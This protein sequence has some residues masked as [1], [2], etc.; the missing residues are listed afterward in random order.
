MLF[1]IMS[2]GNTRSR[3]AARHAYQ[4]PLRTIVYM[5]RMEKTRRCGDQV[6]FVIRASSYSEVGRI[7]PSFSR[8]GEV[9]LS[10]YP[11]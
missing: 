9:L 6:C 1:L 3:A 2:G 5:V 4:L 8:S 11:K 10:R 7:D